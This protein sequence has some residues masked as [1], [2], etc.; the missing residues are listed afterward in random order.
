M[1]DSIIVA[2]YQGHGGSVATIIVSKV[3]VTSSLFSELKLD[4]L[5]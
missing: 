5:G 3:H 4:N 2:H 1:L